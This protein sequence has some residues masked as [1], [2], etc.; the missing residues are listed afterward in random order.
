MHQKRHVFRVLVSEGSGL[1]RI[2]R[3]DLIA[4]TLGYG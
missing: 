3:I 1:E 4:S 2:V